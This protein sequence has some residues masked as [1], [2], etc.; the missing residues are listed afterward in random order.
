MGSHS[1]RRWPSVLRN[2]LLVLM[3]FAFMLSVPLTAYAVVDDGS[4]GGSGGAAPYTLEGMTPDN[5][6]LSYGLY[7]GVVKCLTGIND[8]SNNDVINGSIEGASDSSTLSYSVDKAYGDSKDGSTSCEAVIGGAVKLWGYGDVGQALLDWGYKNPGNGKDWHSD[9]PG[10]DTAAAIRKRVYG[11]NDPSVPNQAKYV[12]YITT[13]QLQCKISGKTEYSKASAAL[14]SGADATSGAVEYIKVKE[15]SADYTTVVEYI[16]TV[17][18]DKST[19]KA[20]PANSP[21]S[22]QVGLANCRDIAK[23][24]S[25]NAAGFQQWA[26][27]NSELAKKVDTNAMSTAGTETGKPTCTIAGIGWIVCPVVNFLSGIADSA[28]GMVASMLTV[29]AVNTSDTNNA[30]YQAWSIV[31]N[32]ANICFV[33][34][35]LVIIYSQITS[36][37]ISNYGIKKLLPKLIISAVL[38]NISYWICALAVDISNFLGYAISGMFATIGKP[39]MGETPTTVTSGNS[40]TALAAGVLVAGA[41]VAFLQLS[42]LLPLLIGAVLVIVVVVII[43]T[44]RQGLIVMLIVISPLAFVAYLLPNTS[45]LFDKWWGAFKALLLMFPVVAFVYAGSALAGKVLSGVAKDMD[46]GMK[47]GFQIMAAALPILSFIT[48]YTLMKTSSALLGKL[49]DNNPA[50]GIGDRMKRGAENRGKRYDNQ[51]SSYALNKGGVRGAL[52]GGRARARARS[53]AV[54]TAAEKNKQYAQQ[55]Y[56][57]E[58]A[59]SEKMTLRSRALNR[60]T[61]GKLGDT[62]GENF[63]GA[64]SRGGGSMARA[65]ATAQAIST[66]KAQF[67]DAVKAEQSTMNSMSPDNLIAEMQNTGLTEARRTAAAGMVAASG[68]GRHIQEAID[69]L[70]QQRSAERLNAGIAADDAVTE[71][72]ASHAQSMQQQMASQLSK[73]K[74]AMMGA[75]KLGSLER[76]DYASTYEADITDRV[77]NGKVSG[78]GYVSMSPDDRSKLQSVMENYQ[79]GVA[80]GNIQRNQAFEDGVKNLVSEVNK[81]ASAPQNAGKV[82]KEIRGNLNQLARQAGVSAS[83]NPNPSPNPGPNQPSQPTQARSVDPSQPSTTQHQGQT[84]NQ[85]ESGLYIPRS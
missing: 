14:K 48:V 56:I 85:T 2:A 23:L 35:F 1:L 36:A 20:W 77:S 83:S 31:R 72:P 64:M 16:Y 8:I 37:G 11:G 53:A 62:R 28:Y 17:E 34:A 65:Q 32:L 79:Q 18:N 50:K 49:M 84:F 59:Q 30:L 82:S 46:G 42:M 10:R 38:V 66:S 4:G 13:L 25:G 68:S 47:V 76:G 26:E 60:A 67:N 71:G 43:L 21:L 15:P 45:K 80:S 51:R 24:A 70:G 54:N 39:I 57:A 75:S 33:I 6:S 81:Y 55:G 29:P 73:Y 27:A 40:W 22:S 58:E 78:E 61:F 12:N 69:Y 5:Q 3:S 41:A 74:P 7:Y 19:N 52:V 63:V 44:L 9:N